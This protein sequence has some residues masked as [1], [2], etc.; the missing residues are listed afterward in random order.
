MVALGEWSS[1]GGEEVMRAAQL[2]NNIVVNFAEVI[3]FDERFIDP[4]GASI[5]MQWDGH[6]FI[7]GPRLPAVVLNAPILAQLA[8]IDGKSIRAL[9]EGDQE[10]ISA[11]ESEAAALRLQ[12]V[13][14]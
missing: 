1:I 4:T 2:E 6:A 12:L 10:R 3:S 8:T 14:D 13:K 7:E 9:R 5:G 11:L